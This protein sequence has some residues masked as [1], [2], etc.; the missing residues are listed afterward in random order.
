MRDEL[1]GWRQDTAQPLQLDIFLE[2][3]ANSLIRDAVGATADE[4][5]MV[6]LERWHL[7]YASVSTPPSQISWP[8]FYKRHMVLLRSI[9]TYLRL[10]PSHRLAHSLAKLG[11]G[12]PSLQYR[13]SVPSSA[14]QPSSTAPDFPYALATRS[15][16]FT[17]PDGLHGKL[18]ISVLYRPD[19]GFGRHEPPQPSVCC[20]PTTGH[21]IQDYVHVPPSHQSHQPQSQAQAQPSAQP[22]QP[23]SQSRS[24]ALCAAAAGEARCSCTAEE[25]AQLASGLM[26]LQQQP[27]PPTAQAATQPAGPQ[28][29]AQPAAQPSVRPAALPTTSAAAAAAPHGH[30]AQP[31]A[32][33]SCAASQQQPPQPTMP[34]HRSIG[35]APAATS[36][37]LGGPSAA[38][39]SL[40]TA[41]A[42]SVP[43]S[44]L[45]G[46]QPSP[47]PCGGTPAMTLP[48]AADPGNATAIATFALATTP[49][50]CTPVMCSPPSGSLFAATVGSLAAT[51][52]R[53]QPEARSRAGS[54]SRARANSLSLLPTSP[55]LL[56]SALRGTMG[57]EHELPFQMEEEM[58][59][60]AG[61]PD[62]AQAEVALG[63][64]MMEVQAAPSLQLFGTPGGASTGAGGLR[65][66]AVSPLSQSVDDISSQLDRLSRTFHEGCGSASGQTSLGAG[67]AGGGA[68]VVRIGSPPAGTVLCGGVGAAFGAACGAAY[69]AA[70]PGGGLVCG[71]GSL[72]RDAS[73]PRPLSRGSAQGSRSG[74]TS[75]SASPLGGS[76]VDN[77]LGVMPPPHL[78]QPLPVIAEPTYAEV[79][80]LS[81]SPAAEST[82]AQPIAPRQSQAQPI[83]V[84]R[85]TPA[86][87]GDDG[88]LGAMGEEED[89]GRNSTERLL[90][91]SSPPSES[92]FPFAPT[93]P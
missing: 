60:G 53:E 26:Q 74:H 77:F 71:C 15:F 91:S 67:G 37:Q 49:P 84:R 76:P 16:S 59:Q 9:L 38:G 86:A 65:H 24:R 73:S 3:A 79:V 89:E 35:G 30:G 68:S 43:S 80:G 92:L 61:T 56:G 7:Q 4:P 31:S 12:G 42:R 13:L 47:A 69:G 62:V 10:M 63:S 40:F 52:N 2:T 11:T 83:A 90:L 75:P 32:A 64:F 23:A 85:S 18:L 54:E 93:S 36:G 70:A 28:P 20:G 81:A 57:S 29:T 78:R 8:G 45:L 14:P 21:L 82:S 1:E 22:P 46:M 39:T 88:S 66:G 27:L 48:F 34:V 5:S 19:A 44:P 72:P 41:G 25:S 33:A 51:P 50:Q 87:A 55:P 6:L 58:Q 17:P